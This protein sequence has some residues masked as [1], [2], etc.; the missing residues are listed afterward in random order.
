[1]T[2]YITH[3]VLAAVSDQ[4]AGFDAEIAKDSR[5]L[6][7]VAGLIFAEDSDESSLNYESLSQNF[8]Q[9]RVDFLIEERKHWIAFR[10]GVYDKI[11]EE[12]SG[13]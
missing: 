7:I 10:E 11:A 4:I 13:S 3:D 12:K 6:S 8:I 1:M 2:N 9:R 5:A